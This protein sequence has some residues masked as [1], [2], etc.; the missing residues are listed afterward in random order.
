M[1]YQ[2]LQLQSV[3]DQ[4]GDLE[5]ALQT[6]SFPEPKAGQVVVQMLAAPINP[7]DMFTLFS[8]LNP[9]HAE[10]IERNG[11]PAVKLAS[12][13]HITKD[14]MMRQ[15]H[16]MKP[17]NE[18]CGRVLAAGEGSYAQSLVGKLVGLIGGEMFATHR[19]I[20]AN[21]CFVFG[22]DVTAE[23]ACSPFVNP[24]T[25]LSMVGTMQKE[26]HKALIHNAAASNLGQMLNRICVEDGIDLINLVR[27][28]EQA[29]LL[30]SQ[31]AR[32]VINTSSDHFLEEL[33][34]AAYETQ[35]TLAFDPVFGGSHTGTMLQAM[36]QASNRDATEYAGYHGHGKRKQVY[37]YGMLNI[38]PLTIPPGLNLNW[39]V[40]S[41]L[42]ANFVEEAAMETVI[43]MRERVVAGIKTTFASHFADKLPLTEVASKA[44]IAKYTSQSTANKYFIELDK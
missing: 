29:E 18:G 32:Y 16:I 27:R 2:G 22:D 41:Y 26:G 39:S 21:T 35:A 37:V 9:H 11:L 3:V 43:A 8:T 38:A 17:G 44:Q 30:K 1:S 10:A 40:G 15:G 19:V 7:S 20:D 24:M 12:Q 31:G 34:E 14:L 25:A 36:E 33:T 23:Q 42:V 28:D 4:D 13:G 5:L 6:V